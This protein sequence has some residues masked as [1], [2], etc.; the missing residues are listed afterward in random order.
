MIVPAMVSP[1]SSLRARRTRPKSMIFTWPRL[2]TIMLA[3]LMSRCTMPN[4]PAATR[5]RVAW[6]T[7]SR[8]SCQVGLKPF[9]MRRARSSPST[10][11]IAK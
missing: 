6:M 10:Y 5:P 7:R 3:G 2:V 8:L 11:S 9:A 1:V 4:S